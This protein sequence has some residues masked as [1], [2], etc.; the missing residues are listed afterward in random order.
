MM[1]NNAFHSNAPARCARSAPVHAG[2]IN[3]RV[4]CYCCGKFETLKGC[5]IRTI[6]AIMQT[7]S[8]VQDVALVIILGSSNCLEFAL[9]FHLDY[10]FP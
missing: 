9:N 3:T 1:Q 2:V 6:Y 7:N 8:R 5:E 10:R 4:I